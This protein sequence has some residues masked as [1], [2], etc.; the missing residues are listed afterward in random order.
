MPIYEYRC[1]A[2]GQMR[3]ALQKI[4]DEPLTECSAC[5]AAALR[6]LISAPAFRLK[7]SGWYETDFKSDKEK[8][9]NLADGTGAASGSDAGTKPK[10]DKSATKDTG[11]A[12]QSSESPKTP[13]TSKPSP[14]AA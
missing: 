5:G 8:K 4:M 3:E 7:G 14:E 2:C 13:S 1:E 12:K 10:D 9:R 6:R 11:S